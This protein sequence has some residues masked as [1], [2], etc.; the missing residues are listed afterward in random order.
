MRSLVT[1]LLCCAIVWGLAAPAARAEDKVDSPIYKHWAR[2]KPGAFSVVRTERMA[3]GPK[4]EMIEAEFTVTTTLKEVT[5]ERVVVELEIV[6]VG[7]NEKAEMLPRKQAY[8]AKIEKDEALKM[9]DPKKG[10]KVEDAEVVGVEQGEEEIRVGDKKI[11][12]KWLETKSRQGDQTTTTKA[13]TSD[14]VPGQVV[15]MV[16]TM[17]GKGEMT[18]KTFLVKY[19]ADG[20]DKADQTEQAGSEK[21]KGEKKGEGEKKE[22]KE[23]KQADRG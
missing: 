20:S 14:E 22:E 17:E 12:C 1:S 5:P 23:K 7:E 15:K 6:T 9:E 19:S 10:D 16:V 13:W 3:K 21:E 4:A 18:S 2:F 8:P 11:K